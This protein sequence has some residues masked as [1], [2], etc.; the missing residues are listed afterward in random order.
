[1]GRGRGAL[2]ACG[3]KGVFC[4]ETEAAAAAAA[5][6][7]EDAEDTEVTFGDPSEALLRGRDDSGNSEEYLGYATGKLQKNGETTVKLGGLGALQ[8]ATGASDKANAV[9]Y[10]PALAMGAATTVP[11]VAAATNNQSITLG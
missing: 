1:M 11:G 6:M 4:L 5:A 9:D 3:V 8:G 7:E 2:G 10:D